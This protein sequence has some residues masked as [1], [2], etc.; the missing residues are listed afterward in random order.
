MTQDLRDLSSADQILDV[1]CFGS[2]TGQYPWG[3]PHHTIGDSSSNR[4][5]GDLPLSSYTDR[6]HARARLMSSNQY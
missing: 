2:I 3:R 5:S 6:K 1:N 4:G